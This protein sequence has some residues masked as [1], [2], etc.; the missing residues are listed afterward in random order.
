MQGSKMV[1]QNNPKMALRDFDKLT[2]ECVY[3]YIC[4]HMY[5]CIYI[6]L[7]VYKSFWDVGWIPCNVGVRNSSLSKPRSRRPSSAR[8][9]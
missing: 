1:S 7:C 3:I 9:H 6:Y 5:V 2:A 8:T 4:I